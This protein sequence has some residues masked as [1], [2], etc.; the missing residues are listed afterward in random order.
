VHPNFPVN[1]LV[2]G[3][4]EHFLARRAAVAGTLSQYGFDG[5]M[6]VTVPID[7]DQIKQGLTITH[8]NTHSFIACDSVAS[9]AGIE[10]SAEGYLAFVR[11]LAATAD[12]VVGGEQLRMWLTLLPPTEA[13][14]GKCQPPPDSP[15]TPFNETAIFSSKLGY[16]DYGAWAAVCGKLAMLYPHFVALQ[17][18]DMSH[19]VQPP[20]GIFTPDL[21]ANMTSGLRAH[22][23]WVNLI[24]TTYYTE[25]GFVWTLWPDLPK[26]VDT[27]LFYFRNQ[28]EGAGP[29]SNPVCPWGPR[30]KTREGGCLA[31]NC[32]EATAQNAA[33]EIADIAAGMPPGRPLQVG[34]Y[35][36]GHSSLG[37][38]TARY[39]RMVMNGIL[40]Q[41]NVAGITFY[42]MHVPPANG[43]VG[44]AVQ[45]NMGCVVAEVFSGLNDRSKNGMRAAMAAR[46]ARRADL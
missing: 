45:T 6:N 2:Y 30:M 7:T 19:D 41:G 9:A 14:S 22:A 18:D 35:A 4:A 26:V 11:L 8:A 21:I 29:C 32:S 16:L 27:V 33:G 36:T 15:L 17:I 23:P 25:G 10:A 13:V 12:F 31:G 46:A 24:S 1:L 34:F 38:P 5:T 28:K 42:R 39:V 40:A 3:R 44:P 37:S 20:A 43:C